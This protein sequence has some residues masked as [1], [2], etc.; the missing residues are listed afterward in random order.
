MLTKEIEMPKEL[1]ELSN[2]EFECDWK[3]GK[4]TIKRLR[5]GETN[6]ISRESTTVK[7]TNVGGKVKMDIDIN[8]AELQIQT[9]LKG[10]VSAPWK[11]NDLAAID[12]LPTP[13]AEWAVVEIEKFNTITFKKKEG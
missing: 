2:E 8:P 12:E 9:L 10:V 5:F 13:V 7:G 3:D 1:F 6:A 11:A 4:V